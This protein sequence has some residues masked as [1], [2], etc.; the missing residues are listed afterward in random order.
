MK[1]FDFG[2]WSAL[3]QQ[4]VCENINMLLQ[5]NAVFFMICAYVLPTELLCVAFVCSLTI[6]SYGVLGTYKTDR[7]RVLCA[8]WLIGLQFAV[9][10]WINSYNAR[11]AVIMGQGAMLIVLLIFD[12]ARLV[13]NDKR[14]MHFAVSGEQPDMVMC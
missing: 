8:I 10:T 6:M 2:I 1:I 5:V 3:G 14:E 9:F 11:R 4:R 12:T 7:W 13:I